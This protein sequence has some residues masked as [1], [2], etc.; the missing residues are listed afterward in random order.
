MLLPSLSTAASVLSVQV[1]DHRGSDG[2]ELRALSRGSE[3]DRVTLLFLCSCPRVSSK[4]GRR[5]GAL[6]LSSVRALH[7][8]PGKPDFFPAMAKV[9]QNEGLFQDTPQGI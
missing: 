9:S 6:G 1:P 5:G 8:S 4:S 7:S 3:M 2:G